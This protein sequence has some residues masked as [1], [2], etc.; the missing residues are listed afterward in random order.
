MDRSGATRQSRYALLGPGP[1][2]GDWE[3]EEERSMSAW[4]SPQDTERI[5]ETFEQ[6]FFAWRKGDAPVQKGASE[7]FIEAK[8][9]A[10]YAPAEARRTRVKVPGEEFDSDWET[11][12]PLVGR[13]CDAIGP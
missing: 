8:V 11:M 2:L 10:T 13:K 7:T 9:P 1:A 4:I 5:I 3:H 6:H 12:R